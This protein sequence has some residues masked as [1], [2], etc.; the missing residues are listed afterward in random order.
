MTPLQWKTGVVALALVSALAG[1]YVYRWRSGAPTVAPALSLAPVQLV[2]SRRPDIVL[3]DLTGTVRNLQEWDGKVL[4][5]N[6]WAS[7]CAP[8]RRELPL[9]VDLQ[10]QFGDRGLQVLGVAIDRRDSTQRLAQALGANYPVLSGELDGLRAAG[11]YGNQ[12]GV[13]PYTVLVD[14]AGLVRGVHAGELRR[15]H[16]EAWL[17]P[18]L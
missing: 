9:L 12:N 17:A 5:I 13:L 18:V 6:F 16:A 3:P 7:W 11:D 10:R 2:G 14:R 15:E 1:G 4:L 8:C